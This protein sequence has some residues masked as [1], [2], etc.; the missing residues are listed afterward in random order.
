MIACLEMKLR[1]IHRRT[2][3]TTLA[4]SIF[5]TNF[6]ILLKILFAT[7]QEDD[8]KE[9]SIDFLTKQK[10]VLVRSQR[11]VHINQKKSDFEEKKYL[12]KNSTNLRKVSHKTELEDIFVSIK[13]TSKNHFTRL[14]ILLDTWVQLAINQTY[15]FT[16]ADDPDLQNILPTGHVINTNCSSEHTRKAL[17]CKMA[18]EFDMYVNSNKHWFC[19]VDDDTYLN[20]QKLVE[21]LQKYNHTLDWYLGKPS[22][23]HPIEVEDR[24]NPGQKIAFWFATGGAGF[25]ISQALAF[26]MIPY[27]GGGKLMTAGEQIR[28]PDDCTIGYIID[29]I[30]HKELTVIEELHSHLEAL[31]Q[32]RQNSIKNQITFSY[33]QDRERTNLV[34]INGLSP[35]KDPTRFYSIHCHLNPYLKK[36]VQ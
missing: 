36:C 20:L 14:K 28:L 31:W 35:E 6:I 19:H 32:I 10:Q 12:N 8:T 1:C 18:L 34:N 13:T 22:L 24:A 11:A 29:Y 23:K 3:I 4:F 17:C 25:C 33:Y 5:F 21:V 30:L 7:S 15:V 16:D 27:A 2:L 26:K 9:H